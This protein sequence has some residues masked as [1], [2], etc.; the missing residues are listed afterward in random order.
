MDK[1]VSRFS[2]CIME[3]LGN[4]T[5]VPLL[6]L[7]REMMPRNW[8]RC[9]SSK[10]SWRYLHKCGWPESPSIGN[11]YI[12]ENTQ[13]VFLHR[14]IHLPKVGIGSKRIVKTKRITAAW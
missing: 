7:F 10:G 8:W 12:A 4:M 14:P 6:Y 11:C 3:I 13:R 1:I 2:S 9:I 5:D